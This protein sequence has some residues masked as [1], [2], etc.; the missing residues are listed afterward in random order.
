MTTKIYHPKI[1]V[2]AFK[3]GT[4]SVVLTDL[5]ALG[6]GLPPERQANTRDNVIDLTQYL[7]EGSSVR[8]ATSTREPAGA[9]GITLVDAPYESQSFRRESRV[10]S[11]AAMLEPMDLIEIRMA[12]DLSEYARPDKG[13]KLPLVM[14]GFVSEVRRRRGVDSQGRPQRQVVISGQSLVGR[15]WQQLRIFYLNNSVIGDNVLTSFRLL[16]KYDADQVTARNPL[17]SEFMESVVLGM[18]GEFL[19]NLTWWNRRSIGLGFSS[20]ELECSARGRIQGHV[21][22]SFEGGSL[23]QFAAMLTDVHAGFNELFAESREDSEVIILRP[24]PWCDPDGRYIQEGTPLIDVVVV[25]EDDIISIESSRSDQG[26]AN[27]CYV[28]STPWVFGSDRL[29]QLESNVAFDRTHAR[30]NPILYGNRVVEVDSSLG[31]PTYEKGT[32][33]ISSDDQETYDATQMKWLRE[34]SNVLLAALRDAAVFERGSMTVRGDEKLRAGVFVRVVE[35]NL[36]YRCYAHRVEHRFD[37]FRGFTTVVNF[38]RSDAF[39][40]RSR[41]RTSP[42]HAEM[43]RIV[44]GVDK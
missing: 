17:I 22:N 8:V 44:K 16:Q 20:I 32:D 3:V 19:G 11:I 6:G 18:I 37:P 43:I 5:M 29:V 28:R 30:N 1:E 34:R 13:Y 24:V 21:A 15:V 4:A 9:W 2:R 40:E 33:S 31:A 23:Y 35:G 25:H 41:M 39:I 36:Q 12:H 7:S 38:E 26:V 27:Y 14:R 42:Y 10:D